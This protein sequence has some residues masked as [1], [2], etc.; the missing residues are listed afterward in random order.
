MTDSKEHGPSS[1]SGSDSDREPNSCGARVFWGNLKTPEKSRSTFVDPP[2][3]VIRTR[4]S[5]HTQT[6]QEST[7]LTTPV[8]DNGP[9]LG[10]LQMVE[11]GD[12][13]LDPDSPTVNELEQ[14]Q[15]KHRISPSHLQRP[16]D[17]D[18]AAS[19]SDL[20]TISHQPLTTKVPSPELD[21]ENEI[22]R[23]PALQPSS[24]ID[25]LSPL[26]LYAQEPSNASYQHPLT[27]PHTAVAP[28][29]EPPRTTDPRGPRASELPD[30][31]SFDMP[32][33]PRDNLLQ[34]QH[35]S[36]HSSMTPPSQ[37]SSSSSSATVDDLLSLSPTQSKPPLLPSRVF[38]AQHH[39]LE[40]GV[41]VAT[42]P[43]IPEPEGSHH[44]E[45][46]SC[47]SEKDVITN[48]PTLQTTTS[49]SHL[50]SMND[51]DASPSHRD[52]TTGHNPSDSCPACPPPTEDGPATPLFKTLNELVTH[53]PKQIMNSLPSPSRGETR[54]RSPA[55]ANGKEKAAQD[56]DNGTSQSTNNTSGEIVGSLGND[57]ECA[58]DMA[59]RK[60]RRAKAKREAERTR[61]QLLSLSPTSANVLSLLASPD[62]ASP[63][64]PFS[65]I[66][67]DEPASDI[68]MDSDLP[69]RSNHIG[70]ETPRMDV[71]RRIPISASPQRRSE[72]SPL[73]F[74]APGPINLNDPSRSPARRVLV[75]F[76]ARTPH[77]LPLDDPNRTP[78]RRVAIPPS[79]TMP[80]EL[81]E[82]PAPRIRID[83]SSPVHH[84]MPSP[85]KSSTQPTLLAS[86]TLLPTN[87]V[88]SLLPFPI[89]QNGAGSS[90]TV[91]TS[92]RHPQPNTDSATTKPSESKLRQPSSTSTSRIARIAAKPYSHPAQ[93]LS[94]LLVTSSSLVPPLIA[95]TSSISTTNGAG[96]RPHPLPANPAPSRIPSPSKPFVKPTIA[97]SSTAPASASAGVNSA[98]DKTC[99]MAIYKRK[100]QR[101]ISEDDL[102]EPPAK[103]PVVM[104]RPV[105]KGMY[106]KASTN[107]EAAEPT[108]VQRDASPIRPLR[109]PG[110]I[111]VRP[112]IPG[113]LRHF[114]T[115]RSS[116]RDLFNDAEQNNKSDTRTIA[117]EPSG[118]VMDQESREES[119]LVDTDTGSTVTTPSREPTLEDLPVLSAPRSATPVPTESGPEL[120]R[121]TRVRKPSGPDA[122]GMPSA[123]TT[124]CKRKPV[125][126]VRTTSMI[127]HNGS[128]SFKSSSRS[129]TRTGAPH[130]GLPINPRQLQALTDANTLRNQVYFADLQRKV[131]RRNGPRPASPTTKIRTIHEKSKEERSKEREARAERRRRRDLGSN[132]SA[133]SEA[134][135][136]DIP[137]SPT[138]DTTPPLESG[139]PTKHA[140]GPGDEEDYETPTVKWDRGLARTI[141]DWAAEADEARERAKAEAI[142]KG[143]LARDP[144]TLHLDPLG[145]VP[146]A[147]V[148]LEDLGHERVIV[149]RF[150]YDDDVEISRTV[151]KK[152]T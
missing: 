19:L 144:T 96:P 56:D 54:K 140:R 105:I 101:M 34:A 42:S 89:R 8:E 80:A 128:L 70:P 87:N 59:A 91:M 149:T 35:T 3:T 141:S 124:A 125:P 50:L 92:V 4:P 30:L 142:R 100:R 85:A 27:A 12:E 51:N 68:A 129:T 103:R 122:L 111:Q 6:A 131:V 63:P 57:T 22:E 115:T 75:P 5:M 47:S 53:T 135:Y 146:N 26:D 67:L 46:Q 147:N 7:G 16:S 84:A 117:A 93:G 81:S 49:S 86:A 45:M 71:A 69:N 13:H 29:T 152:K 23:E 10:I 98:E 18:N 41:V 133:S 138:P 58:S 60:E 132:V 148:P 127:Q 99:S 139:P 2:Q 95:G 44:E 116:S 118:E 20:Q 120:R 65:S 119:P 110:P 151:K 73:R 36:P 17:D 76:D 55:K 113:T 61:Q 21:S 145:N 9:S 62:R 25:A 114:E 94:K 121:T 123:S 82:P 32:T 77:P 64:R 107:P 52:V 72:G 39:D 66:G 28:G 104:V 83:K 43:A 15:E 143:C 14:D 109:I 38:E 78:A 97:E 102:D 130:G 112:V 126:L 108:M 137:S 106:N 79:P 134:D 48:Q 24:P 40:L 74:I 37:L 150:V 11:K 136:M 33:P 1:P 88:S 90:T 31:I